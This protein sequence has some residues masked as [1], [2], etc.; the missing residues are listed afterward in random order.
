MAQQSPIPNPQSPLLI[1]V[2]AGEVSGDVAGAHL[3]RAIR[4][5]RPASRVVAVGGQQ[6]R[7]AGAEVLLDS[8]AWGTIGYH[9]AY[10]RLPFFARR[11]AEVVGLARRLAPDLVVLVD[12]PGFNLRL[13]HRLAGLAPM[14]YYVPPMVYARRG[15]RARKLSGV[16]IR[17]LL[18]LPFDLHAYRAAGA[19]ALYVGHPALD[20]IEPIT[21]EQARVALGLDPRGP[22]LGV[23]PGS[24]AQELRALLPAFLGA[25]SLVRARRADVQMVIAAAAQSLVPLVERGLRRW[26]VPARVVEGQATVVMR[27]SDVLLAASGTATLEAALRGVP[28]VIAYHVSWLTAQLAR[29]LSPLRMVGLPNILAGQE[30]VPEHLQRAVV[31]E[32]LAASVLAILDDP[33]RAERIRADLAAAVSRLGPPGAIERAARAALGLVEPHPAVPEP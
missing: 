8:E 1:F 2:V 9:E 25:A 10:R 4:S 27:A 29:R 12:F 13:A 22:V 21:R 28:M 3:V 17:L 18:T 33:E 23:L 16:P 6:L 26:P 31:P 15:D 11:F 30:I 19:D 7:S 24:R 14:V 5:L 20:L 32:R